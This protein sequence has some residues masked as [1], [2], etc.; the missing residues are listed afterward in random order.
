MKGVR[1]EGLHRSL[2]FLEPYIPGIEH[3]H[4]VHSPSHIDAFRRCVE[5]GAAFFSTRDCSVSEGSFR[6]ALL[7]AGGVMAASTP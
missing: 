5:E 1:R 3:V 6:A 2:V 4:R 7:A